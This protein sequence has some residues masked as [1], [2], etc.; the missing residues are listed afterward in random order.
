MWRATYAPGQWVVLAGPTSLVIMLP[1][2]PHMT[3]LLTDL[4]QDIV[5]S[6][7]PGEF[8]E[9]LAAFRVDLMPS[10][11]AF[12]WSGDQMHSLLRGRLSAVDATTGEVIASGEGFQTW[13]EV[14]LGAVRRVRVEMEP[15]AQGSTLQLPLV[16]GAVLAS[17]VVIDATDEARV[18]LPVAVEADGTIVAAGEAEGGEDTDPQEDTAPEE[19]TTAGEDATAGDV[20][21]TAG[22]E[23]DRDEAASA[24]GAAEANPAGVTALGAA[25]PGSSGG[26]GLGGAVAAGAVGG[27]TAGATLAGALPAASAGE[28]SA[29]GQGPVSGDREGA[30]VG[31]GEEP[32]PAAD[33]QAADTDAVAGREL[34][35]AEGDGRPA[36]DSDAG[37]V[38]DRES[39]VAEDDGWASDPTDGDT[40]TDREPTTADD[41]DVAETRESRTGA[42]GDEP[43]TE[44][45]PVTSAP[46]TDAAASAAPATATSG[47][48][49]HVWGVRDREEVAPVGLDMDDDETERSAAAEQGDVLALDDDEAPLT[50]DAIALELA[51]PA[52]DERPAPQHAEPQPGPRSG[53]QGGPAPVGFPGFGVAPTVTTGGFLPGPM[54]GPGMPQ[55]PFGGQAGPAAPYVPQS[56]AP[57]SAQSPSRPPFPVDDRAGQPGP[58]EAAYGARPGQ[59]GPHPGPTPYGAQPSQSPFAPPGQPYG[60]QGQPYAPQGQPFGPAPAY[61]AQNGFGQN[62][63]GQPGPARPGHPQQPGQPGLPQQGTQN[64][65]QPG[66]WSNGGGGWSPQDAGRGFPHQAP[67][68]PGGPHPDPRF[69]PGGQQNDPRFQTGLQGGPAGPFPGSAPGQPV[70]PSL[71]SPSALPSP[72]SVPAGRADDPTS[73]PDLAASS[74][75]ASDGTVFSTGLAATHKPSAAQASQGPGLVLAATC[76]AGHTNPPRQATCLR[77]GARVDTANPRLVARPVLATL[78]T[79]GGA[80]AQLTDVVLVGRSPAAQQGDSNPILLPVPSPNSDISRTHVRFAAKDWAITVT[81]LHSTNGTMLVLPGRPPSRMV[82]GTPVEV[83]IGAVVDLGDGATITVRPPQ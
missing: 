83:G 78:Q 3:S 26:T 32:A 17:A 29:S 28:S 54:P 48:P 44:A 64:P 4:W 53:V 71:Q 31:S 61:G 38:A 40:E 81:D 33:G 39:G 55:A 69:Q 1:A 46:T 43:T 56:P 37:A 65:A 18:S 20:R 68:Q 58:G 42:A 36:E 6:R 30:A 74:S 51:G 63:Q 14:G 15:V 19:D 52:D 10:L 73:R 12:F 67:P 57:M 66:P 79:A 35:V 45:A 60:Q 80:T 41:Q 8:A 49:A 77:C 7:S 9:R 11:G 23:Q 59:Q 13:H 47:H 24:A 34:A 22:T 16:V 21:T 82:P 76:N 75:S 72:P 27:A 50:Q 2:P 5:T 70:M 25:V 62:V